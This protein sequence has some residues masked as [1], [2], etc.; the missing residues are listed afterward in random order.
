[1]ER[2]VEYLVTHDA[3]ALLPPP[4]D[5][6]AMSTVHWRLAFD[7]E[8]TALREELYRTKSELDRIPEQDY[9]KLRDSVFVM[10]TPTQGR[11][12][13]DTM[14][15]DET[16]Q[17]VGIWEF[18]GS[19][20]PGESRKPGELCFVDVCGGP[21]SFSQVLFSTCPKAK[22]NLRG[23]GITLK[24]P[25]SR[26]PEWY[27]DLVREKKFMAA[28]GTDGTG[29]VNKTENL[30]ALRSLTKNSPLKLVVADGNFDL[31]F[32]ISNY[33]EVLHA[34]LIFSQWLA[35][36]LVLKSSGC[37]IIKFVDMFAPFSRSLVYLSTF[38]FQRVHIVKPKHSR[39]VNS[40]RF[41]VGVG[42]LGVPQEWQEVL[43][44][45]HQR[46]FT[47]ETLVKSLVAPEVMEMDASFRDSLANATTAIAQNQ[48][49]SI[50]LILA[51]EIERKRPREEVIVEAEEEKEVASGVAVAD[52]D[53][54]ADFGF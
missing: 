35:A 4:P 52:A 44:A 15:L 30:H 34:R 38:F 29:N 14:K 27:A 50:K 12:N 24:D 43:L 9:F 16:M 46:S 23:I 2:T 5:R 40:A 45:V 22:F 17:A 53:L 11:I 39:A 19:L 10:E 31:P 18:L 54:A 33:Q 32:D 37:M 21:G 42:F 36:L 47:D 1:M 26:K 3:A 48:I 13:R 6:G 20:R 28:Y 51:A 49:A 7:E 25:H 41:L 8:L